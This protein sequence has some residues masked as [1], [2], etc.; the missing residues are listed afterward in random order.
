MDASLENKKTEARNEPDLKKRH[1]L[2]KKFMQTLDTKSNKLDSCQEDASSR[3]EQT[4]KNLRYSNEKK[5][6]LQQEIK[7]QEEALNTLRKT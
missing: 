3:L 4:R 6:K 7:E 1:E 2:L 5:A